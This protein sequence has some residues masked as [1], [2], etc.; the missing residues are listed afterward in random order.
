[1]SGSRLLTPRGRR[2]FTL[3]ELLVVIAIIGILIAL[4]LPAVQAAREAARR[5]QCANNLK[6]IGL[7]VH[8][9]HDV[10]KALPPVRIAGGTGWA[11]FFVMILPYMEQDQIYDLWDLER[12]YSDQTA[13]AQQAVVNAYY[14]PTRRRP[15][16]AS[17]AEDL[18]PPDN[19]PPPNP[20]S[21]TLE[22]RFSTANN[23]PGAVGDYAACVG[24]MRG[25]PNDPT[26]RH[27]FDIQSNGAIIIGT[28]A[29]PAPSN[30]DMSPTTLVTIWKS[31]TNF[32]DILDGTT[33]T[34]LA[35]EKHVPQ[36][37]FG[38]LKVGDGPIYSGAWTAF[39]ARCAGFEDP[40]ARGPD[41]LTPCTGPIDGVYARKFGS[42]HQGVCQFV[43]C[44]GSVK[45]IRTSISLA[46][47]QNLASRKDGK[48]VVIP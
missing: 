5:T 38:R 30:T 41:D 2:A 27:W 3:V 15:P 36:K 32:A 42:W 6:Q 12:R 39:A 35:G 19:S 17:V 34:F 46:T 24:D 31:N 14:C 37:M 26:Q 7:A 40:L 47:L 45:P 13:A 8:N 25:V 10:R 21:G 28:P 29:A 33:S 1:M 18:Y 22:P 4:L 44:D 11:T 9:Y 16:V 23:D 48:T 43:F 20:G